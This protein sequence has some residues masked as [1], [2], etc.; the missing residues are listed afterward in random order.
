MGNDRRG[1]AL[2]VS[3][4]ILAIVIILTAQLSSTTRTSAVL[5]SNHTADVQNFHALRA[6]VNYAMMMLRTDAGKGVAEDTLYETWAEPYG[7]KNPLQVGDTQVTFRIEDE[8]RRL[9]A[10]SITMQ[11]QEGEK[12]VSKPNP[13]AQKR[14]DRLIQ[15]LGIQIDQFGQRIVDYQD[16]DKE[17]GFEDGDED[18]PLLSFGELLLVSGLN[19]ELVYG[20]GGATPQEQGLGPWLTVWGS[21]A[22][23]IN[24][25]PLEVLMCLHEKITKPVAEKIISYRSGKKQDGTFQSF[26]QIDKVVLT[27]DLQM[28]EDVADALVE[29]AKE[30]GLGVKGT[31]FSVFLRARTGNFESRARVVL[32][33]EGANV[34]VVFWDDDQRYTRME[35]KR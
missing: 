28:A 18:H 13:K 20:K 14:M 6:G 9:N 27:N 25:A 32:K 19:E 26:A 10:R 21:G 17:G 35:V 15:L 29:V 4:L 1:A 34:T 11:V 30:G 12:K 2:L 24:T 16:A 7:E 23:N 5:A 33:R 8:E 22:V 3:L 31:H